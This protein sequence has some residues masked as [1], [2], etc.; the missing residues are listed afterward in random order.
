MPQSPRAATTPQSV[1]ERLGSSLKAAEQVLIAAKSRALRE[2]DLTVP[3]YATLLA[4]HLTPGQSAA[5]LA[6]AA[7]VSP[8]TMSTIVGNLEMKGLVRREVSPLHTRVLV[9]TITGEGTELV[10]AA[11]AKARAIED[12]LAAQ[13]SPGELIAFRDYL[14]R[15]IEQLQRE[16]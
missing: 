9:T 6:R 16:A 15:A 11:D 4:L 7:T 10:V 1:A 8:Q 3:Q 12:A 13:F 14:Q 2:F 5:Q